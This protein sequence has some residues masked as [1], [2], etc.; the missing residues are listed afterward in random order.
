MHDLGRG[1]CTAADRARFA[2]RRCVVLVLSCTHSCTLA[3]Y[4]AYQPPASSDVPARLRA[5]HAALRSCPDRFAVRGNKEGKVRDL[6][7]DAG[8]LGAQ[9]PVRE[10]YDWPRPKHCPAY[11]PKELRASICRIPTRYLLDLDAGLAV[12]MVQKTGMTALKEWWWCA[13]GT[14]HKTRP[15]ARGLFTREPLHVGMVREPLARLVSAYNELL[16]FRTV[17]VELQPSGV[18]ARLPNL[19][20]AEKLVLGTG[21]AAAMQRARARRAPTAAEANHTSRTLLHGL[22]TTSA[23]AWLVA[24][25]S[26]EAET[27]LT[28][29][30]PPP[31]PMAGVPRARRGKK[32]QPPVPRVH[33]TLNE[34]VRFRAFVRS[35]ECTH[36]YVLWSHVASAS[37]F[38]DASAVVESEKATLRARENYLCG[39]RGVRTPRVPELLRQET[40]RDDLA[41]V[42]HAVNA[43]DRLGGRARAGRR[44]TCE[45]SVA[46]RASAGSETGFAPSAELRALVSGDAPLTRSVCR[47]YLQDYLCHGYELPRACREPGWECARDDEQSLQQS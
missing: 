20:N 6:S 37:A 42:L 9:M 26:G 36:R 7:S 1:R 2:R 8:W 3:P 19:A 47:V 12:Y 29:S 24:G 17:T 14:N 5:H 34:S 40:L 33:G 4:C 35:L 44:P 16:E 46:N 32:A 15:R 21:D 25:F 11:S 41:R 38:L 39:A 43:S 31:P 18:R 10:A 45:L 23:I 27:L 30:P 13:F 28:P 22:R